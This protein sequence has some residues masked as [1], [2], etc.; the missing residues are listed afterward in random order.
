MRKTLLRIL[1]VVAVGSVPVSAILVSACQTGTVDEETDDAGVCGLRQVAFDSGDD[2]PAN[3]EHFFEQPC[4]L[5]S[6][7]KVLP[8]VNTGICQFNFNDCTQLCNAPGYLSCLAVGAGCQPDGNVLDLTSDSAA[9]PLVIQCG[10]CV[11]IAGRRPDGLEKMAAVAIDDPVGNFFATCAYLEAASVHAFRIM[12]RELAAFDAPDDLLDAAIRAEADEV[13]HTRM[14]RDLARA[15]GGKRPQRVRLKKQ[16]HRTLEDIALENVVEGCV[17][18]TFS[19]LIAMWQAEHASDAAIATA[20]KEIA[21]DE[22]RHAAF[23]WSVASW[24]DGLLD[25]VARA[26]VSAARDR[27]FVDLQNEIADE[28]HPGL[29]ARAGVPT[30]RDQQRLLAR[31]KHELTSMAA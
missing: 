19:A 12:R 24:A 4:G 11:G 5:P 9:G 29:V 26:R 1:G 8:A 13:K 28:V 2:A 27:A 6:G 17:R 31:M 22:T 10:S 25:D 16:P 18:E 23:S 20:M 14:T 7:V 21:A 30:A 15:H 3:C